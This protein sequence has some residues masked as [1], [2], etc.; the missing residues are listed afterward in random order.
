MRMTKSQQVEDLTNRVLK[1]YDKTNIKKKKKINLKDKL[2][3]IFS[4]YIRLRC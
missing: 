2:W 3:K 1:L 4:Q